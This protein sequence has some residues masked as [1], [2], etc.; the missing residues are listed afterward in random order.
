MAL[1]NSMEK[2]ASKG[3]IA[4]IDEAGR[5]PL[6][7]PVYAACVIL[8]KNFPPEFARDSKK[9]SPASRAKAERIIK[10]RALAWGIGS[11]T[12]REIDR[13][14]I[15]QATFRAMQRALEHLFFQFPGIQIQRVLIDGNRLPPLTHPC[16]CVI[17]GDGMVLEIGAASILAK[18]ARDRY[19]ERWAMIEPVFEFER[20]KGYGTSRHR[21]L[22]RRYGPGKQHRLSFL[23]KILPDS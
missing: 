6:A 17:G 21:E 5:G 12:A 8:P 13:V 1:Y 10:D 9:M 15:L 18:Q 2:T 7:G 14:N 20:H 22:L 19:M 23:R 11:A 3:A 16:S 4:G